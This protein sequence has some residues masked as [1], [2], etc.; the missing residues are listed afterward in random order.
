MLAILSLPNGSLARLEFGEPLDPELTIEQKLN[1]ILDDWNKRRDELWS[2]PTNESRLILLDWL[3]A[4][5]IKTPPARLAALILAIG[6][7]GRQE[8][9]E[10]VEAWLDHPS[11]E[12]KLAVIR[13]LGEIQIFD[14]A[15]KLQPFLTHP[16]KVFRETAVAA[17]GKLWR[18]TDARQLKAAADADPELR[19]LVKEMT[20][21]MAAMATHNPERI[22][23][24]AIAS[25]EYED[26]LPWIVFVKDPLIELIRDRRRMALHRQ[27]AVRLFGLV[28][29]RRVAGVLRNYVTD[30]GEP[31]SLRVEAAIA[32]GR[33]GIHSAVDL[34]IGLLD[35]PD[36]R[37]QEACVVALGMLHDPRALR[38]LLRHWND[39]DGALREPLRLASRRLCVVHGTESLALALRE[40]RQ[41][42]IEESWFI[43]RDRLQAGYRRG[44]LDAFLASPQAEI[45][46]DAILCIAFL[47][48]RTEAARL[49]QAAASETDDRN[50]ELAQLGY[51]LLSEGQ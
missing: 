9:S 12:V 23:N 45:R 33:A 21:Y 5:N 43:D 6:W 19:P 2:I 32:I 44:T 47:A 17:M 42:R 10:M 16:E 1:W 13:A 20:D 29:Y 51:R 7:L 37:L 41:V 30:D 25:R 38:P 35:H 46:R 26:L 36:P 40:R 14:A 24:A 48:R 8:G 34:L 15:P 28:R 11:D 27:R 31:V 3:E 22:A 49:S 18:S 50:R 39:R 4:A